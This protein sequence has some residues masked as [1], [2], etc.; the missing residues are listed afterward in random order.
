MHVFQPVDPTDVDEGPFK[1]T[2][3]KVLVTAGSGDK[4]NTAAASFG[5]VGYL[6]NRR[7]VYIFLREKRFTRELVEQ[8][9]AFSLSFL[10]H[11]EFRGAIKY[12]DAVSGRDENKIAGARLNVNYDDGIPFIDEADNVITCKLLYYQ[13][14]SEDGIVDKGIIDEFYKN[15]DY[16]M[17]YVGEIKKILIR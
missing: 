10:N 4:V 2:G 3:L 11:D 1:F 9:G 14:F 5:A 15:G 7:V 8:N 17:V 16:H 6:W 12:I 13:E